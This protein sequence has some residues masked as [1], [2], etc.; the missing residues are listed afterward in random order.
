MSN[1]ESLALEAIT[2]TVQLLQS[3]GFV[4]HSEKSVLKPVQE[5]EFLG[6]VLN[7]RKMTVSLTSCKMDEIHKLC[8]SLV[9]RGSCTLEALASVIGK[10]VATFPGVEFGPLHYR[11]LERL[12]TAS[13]LVHKGSYKASVTLTKDAIADLEW[14]IAHIFNSSKLIYRPSSDFELKSDAS[15]A[16]WGAHDGQTSIGGRWNSSEAELAAKKS[17]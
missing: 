14:W 8:K 3:L 17:D 13:L 7:S 6:F 15:G 9:E 5:I 16:G 11:N 4:I 1:S 2:E 12:K 10:L